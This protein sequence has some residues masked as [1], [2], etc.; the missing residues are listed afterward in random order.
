ML[1]FGQKPVTDFRAVIG[2][3]GKMKTYQSANFIL[4]VPNTEYRFVAVGRGGE[5]P[6]QKV[7]LIGYGLQARYM[8]AASSTVTSRSTISG[9]ISKDTFKWLKGFVSFCLSCILSLSLLQAWVSNR[10]LSRMV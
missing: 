6:F 2:K 5:D 9:R 1:V 8:A 10:Q 3:V 7:F 4:S